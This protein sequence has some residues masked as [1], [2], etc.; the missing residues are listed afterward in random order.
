LKKEV[1]FIFGR[2]LFAEDQSAVQEVLTTTPGKKPY[3]KR[4]LID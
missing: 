3:N 1:L 2:I 4:G